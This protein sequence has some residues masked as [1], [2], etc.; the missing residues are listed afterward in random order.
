MKPKRRLLF[1]GP[2]LTASGYG[3]HARMILRPLLESDEYDVTVMSTNWGVTPMIRN[4]GDEFIERVRQL[5]LVQPFGDYDVS[6]Q[7]TIPQEFQ[8]MARFNIGITAGIET[9]RV[10]LEWIKKCN[11]NIDLIVVPSNHAVKAFGAAYQ[12]ENGQIIKLEKPIIVLFEGVNTEVY[13][14]DPVE[15]GVKQFDIKGEFNFISVGLGFDKGLGE[16]RKNLTTLVKWFC[17]QFKGNDKV[18][19]VLKSSIVGYSSV[20]LKHIKYRIEMIKRECGCGEFPRI[21]LIH[22]YLSPKEMAALYKHPSVKAY[23]TL[24][25]GEGYGLPIIEAAACGLPVI[26]TD[27][28][29]HLDFLHIKNSRK[30]VPVPFELKQIPDACVW[31]N[32]LIKGSMWAWPQENSAKML[33]SKVQMSYSKPKEWATELAAHIKENFNIE[34]MNQSLFDIMSKDPGL[35]IQR[36]VDG[37]KLSGYTTVYN[38]KRMDY[39]YIE[40]IKSMLG[41]CDE[42]VVVD[43]GST[44]GTLES[45]SEIEVPAGKTLKTIVRSW[46][47]NDGVIAIDGE[48]KQFARQQCTGDFLWQQDADEVV[49]EDDYAKIRQM[50]EEFPAAVDVISLPVI[51]LWNGVD[52]VRCDRHTWKW[53]LS[54]N[55]PFI[56]HGINKHA[57]VIKNGKV[58]AKKGMSDSC[59]YIDLQTGEFVSH[60]G[61]YTSETEFARRTDPEKYAKI[62]ND[63]FKKYPAIFHYSLANIPRKIRNYRDFWSSFWGSMYDEQV[64]Q[65]YFKGKLPSEATEEDIIDEAKKVIAQGDPELAFYKHS[66]DVHGRQFGGKVPLFKLERSQPAL[67]SAWIARCNEDLEKCK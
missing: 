50:V 24:T 62:C 6:I 56:G 37:K 40:C 58:F 25:H 63:D 32:I 59:E 41:F 57:R 39:P 42:V 60:R 45:L 26:A 52:N 33:M 43:G 22:G 64:E 7:V 44:D 67:M 53:R 13:N 11:E 55:N 21:Q 8:R 30:F 48:Q 54:R 35:H 10:S 65:Q 3:V 47:P 17:E 28:S 36:K 27:W 1:R 5:S 66:V 31:D 19:L 46:D 18:G 12:T 14:T 49:H 23:I 34:K 4:T 9:D 38:A 16:D 29:G 2:V 20:D 61:H 15:S 51:E